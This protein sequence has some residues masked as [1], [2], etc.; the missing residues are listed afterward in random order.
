MHVSGVMKH[1]TAPSHHE[2]HLIFKLSV[3]S[4]E[5]MADNI[6]AHQGLDDTVNHEVAFESWKTLHSIPSNTT[7]VRVVSKHLVLI[8]DQVSF[9]HSRYEASGKTMFQLIRNNHEVIIWGPPLVMRADLTIQL[10]LIES[11]LNFIDFDD[12]QQVTLYIAWDSRSCLIPQDDKFFQIPYFV[13]YRCVDDSQLQV[14]KWLQAGW[15]RALL[16]GVYSAFGKMQ[17]R[18]IYLLDGHDMQPSAVLIVSN[19]LER[20]QKAH[21]RQAEL[22]FERI[23]NARTGMSN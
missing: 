3:N 4:I 20:V 8:V 23:L 14:T 1:L 10:K 12:I 13:G 21:W 17:E 2:H 22:L 16:D 15:K 7:V 11:L 19:K 9:Y 6:P 5:S 18:H